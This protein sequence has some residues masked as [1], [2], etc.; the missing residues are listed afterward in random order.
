ME[1]QADLLIRFNNSNK[2]GAQ[3]PDLLKKASLDHYQAGLDIQLKGI[4][5]NPMVIG[6]NP[7]GT[8]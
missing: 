2:S 5:T 8:F 3:S 1:G 7:F 4:I 6:I